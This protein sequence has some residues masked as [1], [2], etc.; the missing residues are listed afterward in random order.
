MNNIVNILVRKH[1][2]DIFIVNL[3]EKANSGFIVVWD[4]IGGHSEACL[5]YVNKSRNFN[6]KELLEI[7]INKYELTYEC[8]CVLHKRI[9]KKQLKNI[10]SI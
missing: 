4:N 7:A 6:N 2:N 8:K 3:D 5:E 9:T 1:K 10:W